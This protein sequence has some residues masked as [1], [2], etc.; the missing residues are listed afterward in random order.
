METIEISSSDEEEVQ[1]AGD[2][3][4]QSDN[5]RTLPHWANKPVSN[6]RTSGSVGFHCLRFIPNYFK[7]FVFKSVCIILSL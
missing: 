3:R 2:H 7:H 4:E 6:K 1:V 5:F